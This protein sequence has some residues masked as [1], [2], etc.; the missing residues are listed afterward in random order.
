MAGLFKVRLK[1]FHG[2]ITIVKVNRMNLE[3]LKRVSLATGL[4]LVFFGLFVSIHEFGIAYNISWGMSDAIR[5]IAE[6]LFGIVF[7]ILGNA[8]ITVGK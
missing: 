7:L 6:L 8:L 2:N 4:V 3:I 5:G 1:I